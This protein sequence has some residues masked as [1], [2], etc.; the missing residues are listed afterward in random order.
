MA[1]TFWK[2]SKPLN[3]TGTLATGVAT[4]TPLL[5]NTTYYFKV[6]GWDYG[7]TTTTRSSLNQTSP[8]IYS[9]YSDTFS[10]TTTATER[11]VNLT[12][13]AV[14]KRN[15]VTQVDG[16]EVLIS[17]SDDFTTNVNGDKFA[18]FPADFT[19]FPTCTSTNSAQV[20][21]IPAT[22]A[23]WKKIPN[24]MPLCMWDGA[25][26]C[27]FKSLY[28]AMKATPGYEMFAEKMTTFDTDNVLA[29]HFYG[30]ISIARYTGDATA[31]VYSFISDNEC[32][33]ING[34]IAVASGKYY[35]NKTQITLLGSTHSGS[36]NFF[37]LPLAGSVTTSCTFR[38]SG[39]S[40]GYLGAKSWGETGQTYAP[41][42]STNLLNVT[43][44]YNNWEQTSLGTT[45]PETIFNGSYGGSI[46]N[47]QEVWAKYY[48]IISTG[49]QNKIFCNNT[50]F[51]TGY[52]GML[53]GYDV[54]ISSIQNN[55]FQSAFSNYV[56]CI[57]RYKGLT[58]IADQSSWDFRFL[59]GGT[60]YG[61]NLKNSQFFIG[62]T[63]IP[64]VIDTNGN[65]IQGAK[66]VLRNSAGKNITRP[67]SLA[68][69]CKVTS[70][71]RT[72]TTYDL[73]ETTIKHDQ[74]N[75][76]LYE[77]A[78]WTGGI[79]TPVVGNYYWYGAEKVK[80][81]ER[82]GTADPLQTKNKLYRLQR[83]IDGTPT[84][85]MIGGSNFGVRLVEAP[86]YLLT[87]VN[88]T[89]NTIGMF[90]N[91]KSLVYALGGTGTRYLSGAV[92]AGEIVAYDYGDLTLEVSKAGYETQTIVL[93]PESA[94][95]LGTEI[96]N[97]EVTLKPVKK[98]RQTIEGKLLL[99]NQAEL[100]SSSKLLEI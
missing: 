89:T 100:G 67:S 10:I 98:I 37:T 84:G 24:G 63:I 30:Y 35:L 14:L 15:G 27:T 72:T 51:W 96:M 56:D 64:T 38:F 45:T 40:K 78:S 90:K 41:I 48:S 88:G 69:V 23:Y 18:C 9:E 39:G 4:A 17:T 49:K 76:Y 57:W 85:W 26:T 31:G 93:T 87:D 77:D 80:V 74:E 95:A 28:D 8:Q 46:L 44:L 21:R 16:Y 91:Y 81:L 34:G 43:N 11:K 92:A 22:N 65:P 54:T 59:L 6:V 47:T 62:K 36:T 83:G 86:E 12:W 42:T 7:N 50:Y 52:D 20:T 33:F 99:A 29:Y 75:V 2:P 60:I 68:S 1:W 70:A 58:E 73:T 55:Y 19:Y 71:T 66:I 13:D 82:I 32:I 94:I 61:P 3:L 5:A 25:S 53:Y 97:V 79:T